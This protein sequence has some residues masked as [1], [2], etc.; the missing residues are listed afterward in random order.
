[1]KTIQFTFII[2][3]ISTLSLKAQRVDVSEK[4]N[5]IVDEKYIGY[6]SKIVGEEDVI[7]K[8]WY[9]ALRGLGRLREKGNYLTVM[10]AELLEIEDFTTPIYSKLLAYDSITEVWVT[11]NKITMSEDSLKLINEKLQVFLYDFSLNYYKGLAQEKIDE[12]ERAFAFTQKKYHKL[13]ADSVELGKDLRDNKAEIERFK[14][15]LEKNELEEK[16]ISQRI[17]DNQENQASTII[18]LERLKTIVEKK[19]ELKRKL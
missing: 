4:S 12:A 17:I 15:L 13:Q 7:E 1:M 6:V 5:R 14:Q 11:G 8:Q 9:K 19:K 18:D 16:V 3:L 10:E 2:T